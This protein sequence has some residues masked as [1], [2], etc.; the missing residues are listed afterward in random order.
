MKTTIRL[1]FITL[2]LS[3]SLPLYAAN[4]ALLI[5]VGE[6]LGEKD[7]LE[8]PAYDVPAIK[9]TLINHWG[10]K[11]DNIK[12]L[13]GYD[14]TKKNI[15][16]ALTSLKNNAKAGDQILF[17]YSGHG[18]SL[19]DKSL[20]LPL[21]DS[22]GALI[23]H[24]FSKNGTAQEKLKQLIIGKTDLK[25]ILLALDKTGAQTFVIFDTCY[26]GNTVRGL[27][28]TTKGLRSRDMP[29]GLDMPDDDYDDEEVTTYTP[30]A[31]NKQTPYPYNNIFFLSAA[32][33]REKAVDIGKHSIP[34]YP[35]IDGNPHGAFTNVLLLALSGKINTDLNNDG[36]LNYAELHGAIKDKMKNVTGGLNLP[37]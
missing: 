11:A 7:D 14:A 15:L 8:G 19:H 35:T 17:Y 32:N 26:S 13:L 29:T 36:K 20:R 12:T 3:T 2:L 33:A 5:G 27:Y 31:Q 25:P 18:T 10:F 21:P 34:Q 30:V 6:Y 9:K 23:P 16:E 24:D 22:S 4:K 37:F 1:L 28:S